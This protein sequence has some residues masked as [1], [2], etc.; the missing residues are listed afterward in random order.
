MRKRKCFIPLVTKIYDWKNGRF[1]E[2]HAE[3]DVRKRRRNFL[4][5][6]TLIELLVV[7][8]IVSLLMAVLMPVLQRVRKQVKAVVCKSIV[9]Q[10]GFI[11]QFYAEDDEGNLPPSIAWGNLTAKQ[12]FWINKILSDCQ[13]K[14]IRFCPSTKMI[15]AKKNPLYGGTFAAWG[16]LGSEG[17]SGWWKD[18]DT[19]SYGINDWCFS[20]SPE[21]DSFWRGRF[22]QENAWRT[23]HTK[24][25]NRVPLFLDCVYVYICPRDTDTPLDFELPPY[26]WKIEW[27]VWDHQAMRLVCIDRHN[28]GINGVF[29]DGSVSKI[30]LKELWTLKWHRK[31][32][33]TKYS[34]DWPEWMRRF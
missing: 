30:S 3:T 10:W 31:F 22:P 5:G 33:T 23:I 8:S 14:K 29:L 32:N 34:D 26:E 18:Y 6:F 28:G 1:P 27:G 7:I 13:G 9:K 20:P 25:A 24:G 2:R 15:H 11:F 4:T 19:G 17:P 16:P 21:A 12:P